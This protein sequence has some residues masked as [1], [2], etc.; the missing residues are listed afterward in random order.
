MLGYAKRNKHLLVYLEEEFE[1]G[2]STGLNNH[3]GRG[4]G[5]SMGGGAANKKVKNGDVFIK[6]FLNTVRTVTDKGVVV[7]NLHAIK[8][9]GFLEELI[10]YGKGNFD[11][12]S[13]FLIGMYFMKEHDYTH[14]TSSTKTKDSV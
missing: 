6:D 7:K 12:V 10:A 2:W 9:P 4:Y 11:R 3:L 5:M 14:T 8:D 1:L 13:C